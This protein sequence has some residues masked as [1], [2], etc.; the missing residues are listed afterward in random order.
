MKRS[1]SILFLVVLAVTPRPA[2]GHEKVF[3]AGAAA[4]DVTPQKFPVVI[5]GNF[6][7]AS[8]DRVHDPLYARSLVLDDAATRVAIVIVDTLLM[9]RELLDEAKTLAQQATGIATDRMM[10]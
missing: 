4:V 7:E 3:R 8:T 2:C 5:S 1:G 6:F 9:P 10:I